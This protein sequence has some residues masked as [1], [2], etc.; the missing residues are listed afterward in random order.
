[1]SSA[2]PGLF[3]YKYL[4]LVGFIFVLMSLMTINEFTAKKLGE[5]LAFAE[6]GVETL[7]KGKKAFNEIWSYRA[8]GLQAEFNTQSKLIKK[9]ATQYDCLGTTV[10]KA[11]KTGSKLRTMRDGYIDDEWDNPTELLEWLGFFQ[12]AAYVHWQLVVGASEILEDMELIE[13]AKQSAV[14][15]HVLLHDV[16]E[17]IRTIGQER[18]K[19]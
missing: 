3:F 10:S 15:H 19:A 13:F 2:T 16:G 4:Y 14:A 9:F 5:V 12:G 1:M 7:D 17:A 18:A 6:V 11:E 8:E